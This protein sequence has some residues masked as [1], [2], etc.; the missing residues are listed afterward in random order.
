MGADLAHHG[1]YGRRQPGDQ[2]H[3][4][5]CYALGTRVDRLP[6][7]VLVRWPRPMAYY[8]HIVSIG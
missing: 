4:E 6:Q 2:A 1:T 7:P 3:G 8:C 5:R